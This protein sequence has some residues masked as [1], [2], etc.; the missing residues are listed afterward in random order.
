MRLRHH[1]ARLHQPAVRSRAE[2]L[3]SANLGPQPAHEIRSGLEQDMEAERR[4]RLDMAIRMAADD[5][6]FKA[7]SPDNPGVDDP[8]CGPRRAGR[9]DRGLADYLADTDVGAD[10]RAPRRRPPRN[11]LTER[12]RQPLGVVFA[13]PLPRIAR[14]KEAASWLAPSRRQSRAA[15]APPAKMGD[16]IP[17]S[18]ATST[19]RGRR[20]QQHNCTGA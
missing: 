1:L 2:D 7:T 3:V 13:P 6:G 19:E 16:I 20:H 8:L 5:I 14:K 15:A 10:Y 9:Q 4:T 12:H 11:R 18:W 17:E